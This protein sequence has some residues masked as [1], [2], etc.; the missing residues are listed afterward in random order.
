[1]GKE[2]GDL[3]VNKERAHRACVLA[4]IKIQE[5]TGKESGQALIHFGLEE[6][7]GVVL[8]SKCRP[9]TPSESR[10]AGAG[11]N[12]RSTSSLAGCS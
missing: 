2:V 7:E 3:E 6:V 1:M 5:Q 11:S 8:T 9:E 10:P 4:V 12:L